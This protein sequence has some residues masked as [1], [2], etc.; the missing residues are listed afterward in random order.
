MQ[1]HGLV[2]REQARQIQRMQKALTQMNVQLTN[3]ITDIVGKT[4]QAIIRAVVAG[5]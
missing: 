1:R 5:E 2:L 4:G 3:V